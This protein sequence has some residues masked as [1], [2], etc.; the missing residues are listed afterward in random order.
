MLCYT[1]Y[2][3]R[4]VV[5]YRIMQVW[6]GVLSRAILG[7]LLFHNK[8]PNPHRRRHHQEERQSIWCKVLTYVIMPSSIRWQLY[9]RPIPPDLWDLLFVT[10]NIGKGNL[11]PTM[12]QS[13]VSV[14]R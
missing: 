5:Q 1:L 3:D 2:I 6:V 9:M 4:Q 13:Y 12:I 14:T 8:R 10:V 11:M 7:W